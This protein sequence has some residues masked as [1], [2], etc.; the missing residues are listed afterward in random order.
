MNE[1]TAAPPRIYTDPS[2]SPLTVQIIG[3]MDM[4]E[5]KLI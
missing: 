4:L 1:T 3:S 2:Q 5:E